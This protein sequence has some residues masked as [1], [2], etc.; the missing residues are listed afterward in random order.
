MAKS[1][2]FSQDGYT[3]TIQSTFD[4]LVTTAIQNAGAIGPKSVTIKYPTGADDVTL[5]FVN[6]EVTVNEVTA[7]IRGALSPTI[8]FDL[9][10]GSSPTDSG[11]SIVSSV[12]SNSVTLTSFSNA[13]IPA[14]SYVRLLTSS[15]SGEVDELAIS[16]DF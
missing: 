4:Q 9:R 1:S 5:F 14:N 6:A 11:T 3:N 2:F 16:L 10:Y 12:V 7:S 15:K 13:T 8:T